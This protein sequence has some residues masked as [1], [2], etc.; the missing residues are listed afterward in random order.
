MSAN[1]FVLIY[2]SMVRSHLEYANCIWSPFRIM[3]IENL[4]KVQKR[5]TRMIYS[6]K[7]MCYEERLR[8]LNLPTLKYRRLRGDMIEAYKIITMKYDNNSVINFKQCDNSI[9]R[10]NRYKLFPVNV[11]YN[12]RKHF[13]SN[14]II[15]TWNSLPDYVVSANSTNMFKNLLD[16]FWNNQE[17][18]FNWKADV[19]GTGSRSF[20]DKFAN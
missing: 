1:T 15:S 20:N 12:L 10:G 11:H 4:E 3:D 13:F 18:K 19:G 8:L 5:A 2:K 16:K 6:V 7:N 14:R 17:F 9:T